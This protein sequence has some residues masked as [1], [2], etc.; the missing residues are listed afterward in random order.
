LNDEVVEDETEAVEGL[1]DARAT[2]FSGALSALESL[3]L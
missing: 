2:F 3:A 1:I